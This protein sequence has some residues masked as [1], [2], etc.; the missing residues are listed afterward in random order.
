M[1]DLDA[2]IIAD[3]AAVSAVPHDHPDR[4]HYHHNLG[5]TL[6]T[7]F[8][9]TGERHDLDDAIAAVAAAADA[10][11][12]ATGTGHYTC[13]TSPLRSCTGSGKTAPPTT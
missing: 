13:R 11:R 10:T 5:I 6:M 4:H 8:D 1:T 3:Q 12:P 9:R 2:A 7:R